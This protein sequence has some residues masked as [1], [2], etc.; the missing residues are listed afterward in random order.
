[1]YDTYELFVASHIF[2]YHLNT[3]I[4]R[5][6]LFVI[7]IIRLHRFNCHLHCLMLYSR[8]CCS[9]RVTSHLITHAI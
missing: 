2:A 6:L 4:H 5:I 8:T 9:H 1:M 3:D 7:T